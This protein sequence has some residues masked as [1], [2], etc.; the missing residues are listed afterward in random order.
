MSEE[1]RQFATRVRTGSEFINPVNPGHGFSAGTRKTPK[2]LLAQVLTTPIKPARVSVPTGHLQTRTCKH[3]I[4]YPWPW[5]RVLAGTGAGRQKIAR[6]LP[7][8]IT[9]SSALLEGRRREQA[10]SRSST[11][12]SAQRA[13]LPKRQNPHG[14]RNHR[15]RANTR[16]SNGVF[17]PVNEGSQGLERGKTHRAKGP[18]RGGVGHITCTAITDQRDQRH[19]LTAYHNGQGP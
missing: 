7:V 9:K 5:V 1:A 6:G 17:R 2:F 14:S 16:S 10:P 4:P 19:D 13:C 11:R 18:M 8:P 3:G 12:A 15:T